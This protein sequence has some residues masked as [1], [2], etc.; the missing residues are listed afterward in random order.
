MLFGVFFVD[1]PIVHKLLFF[2][3]FLL[4]DKLGKFT[5]ASW[6]R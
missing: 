2:Y 4:D 5:K 1:M 6:T 3:F